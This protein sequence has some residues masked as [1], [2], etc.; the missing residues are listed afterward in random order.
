MDSN[1]S[2]LTSAS[3]VSEYTIEGNRT[4]VEI[5]DHFMLK[6]FKTTVMLLCK[7][8]LYIYIIHNIYKYIYIYIYI[9]YIFIYIYIYI[10]IYIIYLY[11][12]IYIYL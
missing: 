11:I 1:P 2:I 10:F 4:V 9:Y 5:S 12:Y 3:L 6:S 7:F 8:H